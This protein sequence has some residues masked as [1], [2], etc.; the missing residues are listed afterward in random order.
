MRTKPGH[1]TYYETG[2]TYILLA[3]PERSSSPK[4]YFMECQPRVLQVATGS[5]R[6]ADF[7]SRGQ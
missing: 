3:K 5:L 6:D 1:V 2:T 7:C 4:Q